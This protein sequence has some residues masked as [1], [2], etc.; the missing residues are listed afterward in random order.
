MQRTVFLHYT[1]GKGG[2]LCLTDTLCNCDGGKRFIGGC[3]HSVAILRHLFEQ[4]SGTCEPITT[5][6]EDEL[7][8]GFKICLQMDIEDEDE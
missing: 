4:K 1:K 8:K 3:A 7:L 6:S 2:R 5:K